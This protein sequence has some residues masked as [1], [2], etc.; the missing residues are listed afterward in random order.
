MF[1]SI[2]KFWQSIKRFLKQIFLNSFHSR[3]EESNSA[4]KAPLTDIEYEFL[5]NQL[6]E[7]V[8]RG[9]HQGRVLKFFEKLEDR[10]KQ[11]DW[12]SWLDRFGDTV[13]QS[14]APNHQLASRIMKLAEVAQSIPYL[15]HIGEH[16]YALGRK[17]FTRGTQGEV[18]EYQGNDFEHLLP[19]PTE[20]TNESD[21]AHENLSIEQL[22]AL[23]Q[24]NS[25]IV[26]QLSAQ[27]GL[28]TEDPATI[29]KAILE[30]S[31]E[32]SENTAEIPSEQIEA[33]KLEMAIISWDEAL[34][35]N[36]QDSKL[37]YNKATALLNLSRW[38][39]A[40]ASYDHAAKID[41][42]DYLVWSGLAYAYSNTGRI[43]EAFNCW[44][45]VI[46]LKPD[47]FQAWS[48]RGYVLELLNRPT[49]AIASYQMAIALN[50]NFTPALDRLKLLQGN[51]E[52]PS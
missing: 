1:E 46:Q 27:L 7:G 16:C 41:P 14:S 32:N 17:I 45:K 6:L 47:Y 42:L 18:W 39:E 33:E 44:E 28:D 15:N 23:L 37:W 12:I 35:Q 3:N 5:F 26:N 34:A 13:L 30:Q 19:F 9:W 21:D 29:I 10:S 51:P 48:D 2:K 4:G 31:E 36:P 38:D 43:E 52:N 50:N 49:E 8:S 25:E 40:L 22:F 24:E 20:D 11:R